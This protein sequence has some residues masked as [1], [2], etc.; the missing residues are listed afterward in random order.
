LP[1]V[2]PHCVAVCTEEVALRD[3]REYCLPT[4]PRQ[5]VADVEG[6]RRTRAVVP[7]HRRGMEHSTAV[8]AG[9]VFEGPAPLD[10]RLLPGPLLHEA[11]L[12]CRRVIRPVV[13]LSARLTP[14]LSAGAVFRPPPLRNPTG[15]GPIRIAAPRARSASTRGGPGRSPR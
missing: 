15:R 12:T 13:D 10:S 11:Q 14:R 6:L 3:L 9:P 1:L 4:V 2:R 8:T 5:P 7:L